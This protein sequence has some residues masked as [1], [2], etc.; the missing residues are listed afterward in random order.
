MRRQLLLNGKFVD[1]AKSVEVKSPWDQQVISTVAQASADQA[2][3]ALAAA[4]AG[5]MRLQQTS[6]AHRRAVLVGIAAGL[7]AR[8]AELAESICREAGKP[9]SAAKVEVDRAIETFTLAAAELSAFGGRT[10]A[11]DTLASGAGAECETR[12]FP[13]GV[14]VGIVPFNFPLNLG[15]H[16]VA[17]A[18][19]VGAPI[20]VKPPPQ[21]PSAQLMVGEL[22]LQAGADPAALQV[23]PCDNQVAERLATDRRTRVLSFTGS[24][25]VGWHLKT[26][27]AGKVVLELGGNAAAI[28]CA[29]ANLDEAAKR[30]A[31]GAFVYAGQVCIRV[32]R[33]VVEQAVH[34][35]FLERFLREVAALKVG[36]P[37]LADTVVGPVIDDASAVRIEQ[38][39]HEAT[40][41]GAKVLAGVAEKGA[42][43]SRPCSPT[44]RRA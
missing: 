44:C 10:L 11:V 30:L 6:T 18:L 5:R 1:G 3:A 21:A 9:M 33:I 29:D 15:A 37:S 26:K 14:V 24:A 28:V 38:W 4:S 41:Q 27:A 40:S 42:C 20:I 13:A 31:A 35:A 17:A 16:K 34:R 22:A 7:K 23:L 19:A 43:C 2:Q 8:G 12:R 32:Q 25:K 39:V 36:D